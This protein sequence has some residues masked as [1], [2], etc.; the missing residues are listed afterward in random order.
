[1]VAWSFGPNPFKKQHVL[2]TLDTG[3]TAVSA[4]DMKSKCGCGPARGGFSAGL[5]E[6]A[7]GGGA[8]MLGG[9]ETREWARVVVSVGS[10]YGGGGSGSG[11]MGGEAQQQQQ[12][13]DD[14]AVK[15]TFRC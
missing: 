4:S 10:R 6:N 3:A 13:R 9:G 5:L 14:T 1:M 12:Q 15:E 8:G 7:A 11:S 2:V